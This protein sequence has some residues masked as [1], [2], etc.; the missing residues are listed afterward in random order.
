MAAPS[1]YKTVIIA[2]HSEYWSI[3]AYDG[4]KRYLSC[5]GRLIVL[6]GNTMYWRVSFSPD[7]TV[8]ECRKVDGAGAQIN[9]A[10]RRGEAWHSDDGLRGGLMRECGFPE[11]ELTG[12]ETF[13]IL[14][15]GGSPMAPVAGDAAFG[16]F[17]VSNPN[18]FLFQGTGVTAAQP[19]AAY[20][21]GHETDVRVSTLQSKRTMDGYPLPPPGAAFP[22]EA[23]GITTL[24][25]GLGD[26]ATTNLYPWDYFLNTVDDEDP[27]AE[28][29][30]WQRPDGGR[31]FNG[32]AIGSGIA[33]YYQDPVF[34]GVMK[35]V[36]THFL[37]AC[38]Y[39]F[40]RRPA[41]MRTVG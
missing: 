9:D 10:R 7:G 17:Y 26:D 29:I 28:L 27:V 41:R 23:P 39:F 33:L 2:G 38:I 35:N 18:H 21:L 4:V 8:M 5:K 32:G 40:L 14:N 20:T 6:S 19:F 36:L 37:G 1:T 25:K 3:A 15:F 12:L 11:W 24:A 31:V 34:T 16:T 30:Y 13:G 22:V